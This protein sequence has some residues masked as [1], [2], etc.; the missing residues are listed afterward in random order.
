MNWRNLPAAG[1]NAPISARVFQ[2]LLFAAC[3]LLHSYAVAQTTAESD[4][5]LT[6][7]AGTLPVILAAPHGGRE[8]IPGITPRQGVGVPQFTIARDSNTAELAESVAVK[9]RQRLGATPFLIIARFERKFVDVNRDPAAAY[10]TPQAK[11]Y[12]ESYHRAISE[13]AET[14]RQKWGCGLLLDIHAQGT[15]AESIFR[16]TDNGRSVSQLQ[17]QH[18]NAALTG[19]KSLLGHL[20]SIGYKILPDLTGQD[21]E[22]LYTGGFTTRRYG[23]HQGTKIDAI[24]LEIGS[25]LRAKPNLE[26]TAND[27]A[28]AIEVFTREYLLG[29]KS[30]DAPTP[31]LPQR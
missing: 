16:G 29:R 10:E 4:K 7:W 8:P 14:I 2:V 21:R 19:P 15:Q 18:G 3:A 27:L 12:Y 9:L 6:F 17:K 22:T 30:G 28:H 1:R 13:S 5:L 26:R 23:S 25:K 11:P 24:Q 20:A 31:R